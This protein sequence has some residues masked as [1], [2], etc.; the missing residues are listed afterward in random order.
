MVEVSA[1]EDQCILAAV[2]SSIA[3]VLHD[4]IATETG[5]LAGRG[6]VGGVPAGGVDHGVDESIAVCKVGSVAG[7][8]PQSA[9][10]RQENTL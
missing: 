3:V 8:F 1:L 10:T 7:C 4:A 6:L 9:Q 5:P 2:A